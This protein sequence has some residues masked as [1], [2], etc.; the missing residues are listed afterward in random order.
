MLKLIATRDENIDDRTVAVRQAHHLT[1]GWLPDQS[2]KIANDD[3]V[4]GDAQLVVRG[5]DE[6]CAAVIRLGNGPVEVV[7]ARGLVHAL[8]R[9]GYNR[10]TIEVA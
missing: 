2:W 7:L 6:D 3:C 9:L 5:R 8:E 4:V 10:S 1:A